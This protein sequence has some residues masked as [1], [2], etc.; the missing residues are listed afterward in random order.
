[1]VKPLTVKF[2]NFQSGDLFILPDVD[3]LTLQLRVYLEKNESIVNI[4]VEST[5]QYLYKSPDIDVTN[6]EWVSLSLTITPD[7]FVS[8]IVL[9]SGVAID[10]KNNRPKVIGLV[11]SVDNSIVD[12]VLPM[13]VRDRKSVV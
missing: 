3:R 7:E 11:Y 12:R 8:E 10:H 2:N 9:S 1:M 13:C 6:I 4:C 5:G